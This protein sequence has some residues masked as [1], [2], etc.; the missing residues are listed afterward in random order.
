MSRP[1]DDAAVGVV[2]QLDGSDLLVGR[3]SRDGGSER[4]W[5]VLQHCWSSSRSYCG[6]A[7]RLGNGLAVM[8]SLRHGVAPLKELEE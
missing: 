8:G 1:G 3:K 5:S 7:R 6:C 2:L 4:R